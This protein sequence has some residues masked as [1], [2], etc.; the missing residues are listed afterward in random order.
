MSSVSI[1]QKLLIDKLLRKWE[2]KPDTDEDKARRND[3]CESTLRVLNDDVAESASYLQSS[4]VHSYLFT[5]WRV[6]WK[7]N[8][9][10]KNLNEWS[11]LSYS[12]QQTLI[13]KCFIYDYFI[14]SFCLTMGS[15]PV[16][17]ISNLNERADI[18]KL[19]DWTEVS[20][21]QHHCLET[22]VSRLNHSATTRSSSLDLNMF[23]KMRLTIWFPQGPTR[24]VGRV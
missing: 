8:D 16:R 11:L 15:E 17:R 14:N 20:N 4:L 6:L 3:G 22:K 13:H 18:S 1:V 5:I 23:M 24:L 2:Q 7:F 10:K 21:A 19:S 9:L 12:Q